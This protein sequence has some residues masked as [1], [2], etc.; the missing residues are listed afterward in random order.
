MLTGLHALAALD[1]DHRLSATIFACNDLDAGI[2]RVELLVESLGASV[3]TGQ[4]GH[5]LNIFLYSELL[6]N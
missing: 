4:T 5:A 1:A 2:I 6:H 3:H